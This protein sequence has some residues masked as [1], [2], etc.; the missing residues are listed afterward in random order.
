MSI[1]ELLVDPIPNSPNKHHRNC[2]ADSTEVELL[3]ETSGVEE[4][5]T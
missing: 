4:L 1:G 5:T 2:M 3:N